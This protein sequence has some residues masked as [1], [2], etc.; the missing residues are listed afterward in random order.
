MKVSV[1][2]VSL[3]FAAALPLIGALPAAQFDQPASNK[4]DRRFLH[5]IFVGGAAAATATADFNRRALLGPNPIDATAAASATATAALGVNPGQECGC[6]PSP[7]TSSTPTSTHTTTHTTTTTAHPTSIPG[8][9]SAPGA[10]GTSGVPG[11]SS[12]S[13]PTTTFT[14]TASGSGKFFPSP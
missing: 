12:H 6:K 4:V 3:I 1:S 10:P 8:A 5:D 11:G 13:A 2:V 9:P 14:V 7:T